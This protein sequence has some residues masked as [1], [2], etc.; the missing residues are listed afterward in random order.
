[1][2]KTIP[3]TLVFDDWR[4]DGHPDSIYNTELGVELAMGDLHAGTCFEAS[5]TVQDHVAEEIQRAWDR[6]GAYPV[7]RVMPQPRGSASVSWRYVV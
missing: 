3:A 2:S 1:M 4:Q 7:F 6:H 5:I